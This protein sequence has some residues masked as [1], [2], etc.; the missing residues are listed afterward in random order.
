MFCLCKCINELLRSMNTTVSTQNYSY[1]V[2]YN[3]SAYKQFGKIF[4][5]SLLIAGINAGN[6]TLRIACM[7]P[8]KILLILMI[9]FLM[10]PESSEAQLFGR[11][12]QEAPAQPAPAPPKT[13]DNTVKNSQKFDG[14]FT[15]YQDT[16]DGST[17]IVIHE[18]QL[19]KEFIYFSHTVDGVL[20]AGHFRG[21][22]RDNKV[23]KIVKHFD[24]I[25][26]QTVN[27]SFHFD[28]ESPLSRA[29]HANI[30]KAT[31]LSEK[32][33]L[34]E[35][36]SGK[37]LIKSDGL[38]LSENMHQVKP[39]PFPGANPMTS[40]NLGNFN[41]DKSKYLEIRNYPNN[42]DVVVEFVYDNPAPINRGGSAVTDARSVGI[43]IQHSFIEMPEN[44][45]RPRRDDPRIGYFAETI[46]DLTSTSATP[47][48]DVITRWNL[49][50]KDP[51]A[52][53]SEP[54]EPIVWWI[55]NTT[56]YEFRETIAN[57]TLAWNEAFEAAGF[58]NAIQVKVQPDTADWDAGDIRYNVLRWTSSPQPPFGGYGPSFTN[59][60]TGQILGADIMLEFVFFTGRLNEEFLFTEQT[61][62]GFDPMHEHQELNA[63]CSLGH[64][65]QLNN[66]F[67]QTYLALNNM[68]DDEFSEFQRQALTMLVLHE[69]GHTFGLNHNMKASQLHSPTDIHSKELA[70]TIGLT[71]SVM[72][73]STVNVARDRSKQG[74]YYDIKPGPYDIWAI[75][76]GYSTG[77]DNAAAEEARLSAIL[78]RSSERELF[79]G[80]D[81]EDM[82]APGRGIDP[83]VMIDDMSSD[84]IAYGIE[85]IE[86]VSEL[87]NKLVDKYKRPGESYQRMRNAY[88]TLFMHHMIQAGVISRYIGGVY[89][90]RSFI[91]QPGAGKPYEPVEKARQKQAMNALATHVFAPDVFRAPAD[92]LNYL[93]LQRRGFSLP[94]TN[95]DP[96]IHDQVLNMQRNVFNHLMHP[97]VMKRIID[98]RQYGNEY[99][100]MEMMDDLTNALFRADMNGNVNTFRQNAQIEYINR[101]LAII[102]NEGPVKYDIPAQSAA[103]YYV[104]QIETQ[105]K[106]KRTGNAETRAHTQHVL[107]IIDKALN[108]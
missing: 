41:R 45:F 24:R 106:A 56:P 76:Y 32:I 20:P 37:Y 97:I 104:R 84:G 31:L 29:A 70:E 101:L 63:Y 79:F 17:H 44:D 47:F 15:V 77:L 9:G 67:G 39:S 87:M 93:Q 73:Y 105:L 57:A 100:L 33:V 78:A 4:V 25:E 66:S 5:Y 6:Y 89:V 10:I 94:G 48:K 59:P 68:S 50:K 102:A 42:L 18:D 7:K 86:L 52:E 26:F 30:S 2:R 35:S 91:G 14:I 58:R 27:T 107:L 88:N 3:S 75:Q 55:E 34:H 60:R 13:I 81:A 103:L 21:M 8:V 12:R 19:N 53:I 85:R 72:D 83:R 49:V 36:E 74:Y 54:V 38:F 71:G 28:T 80:N 95:E 82:R 65:M 98:S 1:C 92:L 90:D 46:T 99:H 16:T 22:Y 61:M 69:L 64:K 62:W 40:F 23:F 43:I 51:N 11:K 96:K 108:S